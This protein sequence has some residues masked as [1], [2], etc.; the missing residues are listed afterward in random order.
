[1][2]V[3]TQQEF[4]V[5]LAEAKL[6]STKRLSEAE[7]AA[8]GKTEPTAVAREL[9]HKGILSRWQ[10]AQVLA[11]KLPQ[12]LGKYLLIDMLDSSETGAV[13]LAHHEQMNRRVILKAVS[14]KKGD[15]NT[16][17][18]EFIDEAQSIAT[19][20][21]RN[22]THI[23][24]VDK[25]DSTFYLVMEYVPGE[26]LQELVEREGALPIDRAVSYVAQA[27]SGLA[28]A[29]LNDI[30]HHG[31][32]P[33]RLLVDEK[34]ELK[35]LDI[36]I[37]KLVDPDE[38]TS[39]RASKNSRPEDV[40]YVAPEQ[41]TGKNKVDQRADIYSLG[42][43]FYF[44]LTGQAPYPAGTTEERLKAR[45]R[46]TPPSVAKHRPDVPDE[47]AELCASMMATQPR[48]RVSAIDEVAG[49]CQ[50][51]LKAHQPSRAK[52]ARPDAAPPA[53]RPDHSSS[54]DMVDFAIQAGDDRSSSRRAKTPPLPASE[55][56]AGKAAIVEPVD[57][58]T[59]SKP[60]LFGAIG[61][62]IALLAAVVMGIIWLMGDQS[63]IADNQPDDTKQQQTDAPKDDAGVE[64]FEVVSVDDVVFEPS[65]LRPVI[66]DDAVLVKG[67][68]NGANPDKV[69]YTIVAEVKQS[70]LSGFRIDEITGRSENG[71]FAISEVE[72]YALADNS[73][74][75]ANHR[76]S[77]ATAKDQEGKSADGMLDHNLGTYW[78]PSRQGASAL[79]FAFSE[80][81]KLADVA[82]G[83]RSFWLHIVV[84]QQAGGAQTIGKFRFAT[85]SGGE[86]P[87][88]RPA[89][90]FSAS[91]TIAHWRFE[92][93]QP[94]KPI[95]VS[96]GLPAT[97][98]SSPNR[99][100]LFA[101]HEGSAP[102]FS[103]DTCGSKLRG[104]GAD[105]KRSLDI[106]AVPVAG[107]TARYLTTDPSFARPALDVGCVPLAKWTVE[108]AFKLNELAGRHVLLCKSGRPTQLP[109]PAFELAVDAAGKKIQVIAID[110][111]GAKRTAFSSDELPLAAGAWYHV[112]A[113]SDG[114]NLRLLVD[115]PGD[116]QGYLQQ[117]S[118]PFNGSLIGSFGQWWIGRGCAAGQPSG[119][120]VALV[121]EIR[122]SGAAL[123]ESDL[124][125][126]GTAEQYAQE[127]VDAVATNDGNP[128]DP[129]MQPTVTPDAGEEIKFH[130]VKVDKDPV[131]GG[132]K[133]KAKINKPDANG[134]MVA[135][136]DNLDKITYH[137]EAET[138]QSEITGLRLEVL[139]DGKKGAGRSD[140]GKFVLT[141]FKVEVADKDAK[142]WTSVK[143]VNKKHGLPDDKAGSAFA[144]KWTV[145]DKKSHWAVFQ[146][147]KPVG[148]KGKTRLKIHLHHADGGKT[149]I[150]KF[151]LAVMTGTKVESG[152]APGDLMLAEIRKSDPF[153][154][155]QAMVGL[156]LINPDEPL[157]EDTLAPVPLGYVF[158]GPDD[159]FVPALVGGDKGHGAPGAFSLIDGP[160][161][162]EGVQQNWDIQY[163]PGA[164]DP[165]VTVARLFRAG[166]GVAFQWRKAAGG[167]PDANFL[168]NCAMNLRVGTAIKSVV[169]RSALDCQPVAF[170]LADVKKRP[171]PFRAG[172]PYAP[173]GESIYIQ[174][175]LS[176]EDDANFD[177][178]PKHKFD[179]K[180]SLAVE[181]GETDL[182]VGENGYLR[183]KLIATWD[184]KERS[185]E[186]MRQRPAYQTPNM[187]ASRPF[188]APTFD[189]R[190]R[191]LD[192]QDIIT[193]KAIAVA[194]KKE[195]GPAPEKAKWKRAKAFLKKYFDV[196]DPKKV[197]ESEKYMKL[198]KERD[199]IDELLSAA[200][201]FDE[202]LGARLEVRIYSLADIT[203]IELMRSTGWKD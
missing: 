91:P 55:A 148:F 118:V 31:I 163:R 104:N 194:D 129:K 28:H 108:A 183:V 175:Q 60:I 45:I 199:S 143:F 92:E 165:P 47:I 173:S 202:D 84:H 89:L 156:P 36:G 111:T 33:D 49:R 10:A 14:R 73:A 43:T 123:A 76:Q 74:R 115:A 90:E 138:D 140:S 87:G 78:S 56:D 102:R 136:G 122:I 155:M 66:K 95:P 16:S 135:G 158:V 124:L 22:I 172:I 195:P 167:V 176:T 166:E 67:M 179:P 185:F 171:E 54:E 153:A 99:N 35:I 88:A 180:S 133:S 114:E 64:K 52:P 134:W 106:S 80:P 182:V 41:A 144:A 48:E 3:T 13:F 51:W 109:E 34:G 187:P 121:D 198:I 85:Q 139:S 127:K 159:V 53:P 94:N 17:V 168:R 97:V 86:T 160:A 46:K 18:R 98:D 69:T 178:L 192:E 65:E 6:L 37:A 77:I 126:H 107:Q 2:A 23:F 190:L 146:A 79:T 27:A 44:L 9:V 30:H 29:H 177:S 157:G 125:F 68:V 19:L 5:A 169:F 196:D 152:E 8:A 161:A 105:N 100:Q 21:H 61:G 120:S 50:D 151:R 72:A 38:E 164:K 149:T 12:H 63:E 82:P 26:N 32:K 150:A 191:S 110:E 24:D 81:V 154:R 197:K 25:E 188:N 58:R 189:K 117:Q 96:N 42:C 162:S 103:A 128:A 174:L 131:A 147:E 93:G 141:D 7:E 184:E 186:L 62:G 130:L 20:D 101:Q 145:T 57:E 181:R 113:I 70:E 170:Q 40:D 83:K 11:K 4:F 75:F 119:K 59:I 203:E 1:M 71:M 15:T 39:G 116:G 132:G 137:V 201:D 112:A 200:G 193:S 142:K